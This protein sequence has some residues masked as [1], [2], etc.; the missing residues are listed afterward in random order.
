MTE[1]DN[2]EYY[3]IGEVSKRLGITPRTIRYYE[4]L[5]LL[6]PPLRI[7]KGIRFYSDEDI[8]R[9]KFILKLKDLGLT[10]KEMMELADI[11][12][13]HKQPINILPKLVEILDKHLEKI[14]E[15]MSRLASLRR[16]IVDYRKK[17][18]SMLENKY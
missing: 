4:E 14:D 6:D 5:G 3:Q 8:K 1:I 18:V 13:Q 10:L 7:E 15:K 2:K 9:I 17:I 11:Y 16:D 12:N